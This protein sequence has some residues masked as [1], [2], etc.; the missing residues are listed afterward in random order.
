MFVD[1]SAFNA[2]LCAIEDA[3]QGLTTR[4]RNLEGYFLEESENTFHFKRTL[5]FKVRDLEDDI[6]QLNSIVMSELDVEAIL[7]ENK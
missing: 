1:P 2:R 5:K 3:I 6:T 4:I 7:T